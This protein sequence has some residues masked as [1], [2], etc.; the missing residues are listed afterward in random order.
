MP[1]YS[2]LCEIC[3]EEIEVNCSYKDVKEVKC[4]DQ[5]MIILIGN[6]MPPII[7]TDTPYRGK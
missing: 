1:T 3:G 5:E 7:K 6:T 2:L 4:C